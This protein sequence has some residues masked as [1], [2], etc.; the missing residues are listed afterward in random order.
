MRMSEVSKLIRIFEN[1]QEATTKRHIKRVIN[2][3]DLKV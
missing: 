3:L 2:K 1:K